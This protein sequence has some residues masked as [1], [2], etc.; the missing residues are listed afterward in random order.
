MPA[1]LIELI[2]R[3]ITSIGLP[4]LEKIAGIPTKASDE[5]QQVKMRAVS[6]V[7]KICSGVA[8]GDYKV[9]K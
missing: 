2:I 7:K 8:C 3:I 1:W 9:K 4:W 5:I 6:R